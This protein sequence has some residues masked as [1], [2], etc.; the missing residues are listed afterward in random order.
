MVTRAAHPGVKVRSVLQKKTIQKT[1]AIEVDGLIQVPRGACRH[2][3]KD[4]RVEPER[5]MWIEPELISVVDN[6]FNC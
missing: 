3:F 4:F 1:A 2:F 6:P 5:R